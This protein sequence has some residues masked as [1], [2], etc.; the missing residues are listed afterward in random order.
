MLSG[1]H[2]LMYKERRAYRFGKYMRN[3][4]RKLVVQQDANLR[5]AKEGETSNT[6]EG[7]SIYVSGGR[8][9]R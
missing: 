8:R 7:I 3:K 2:E 5:H 4:R 1:A 6:L 9:S